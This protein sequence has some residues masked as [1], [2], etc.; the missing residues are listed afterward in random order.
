MAGKVLRGVPPL[1]ER[2]I[3]WGCENSCAEVFRVLKVL[4]NVFNVDTNVL[5]DLVG[6]WWP[7]FRSVR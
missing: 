6:A 3:S 4:V 5:A 1:A 7:K 2:V